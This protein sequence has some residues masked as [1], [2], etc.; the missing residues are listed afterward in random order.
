M[1][2]EVILCQSFCLDISNLVFGVNREYLDE[3]LMHKFVKMM[4]INFYVLSPWM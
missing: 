2:L 4:I 3:S 1:A